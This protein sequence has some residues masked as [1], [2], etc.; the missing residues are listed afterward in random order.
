[1]IPYLEEGIQVTTPID[2]TLG[3]DTSANK[4]WTRIGGVWKGVTVS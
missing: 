2:G 4:I 3:V 1:M